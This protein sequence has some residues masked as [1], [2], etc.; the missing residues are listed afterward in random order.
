MRGGWRRGPFLSPLLGFLGD[1]VTELA[2][3]A[4]KRLA[5]YFGKLCPHRTIAESYFFFASAYG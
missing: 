1:E 5:A 2:A 3:R 4:G